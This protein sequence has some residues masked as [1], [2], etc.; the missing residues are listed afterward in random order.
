MIQHSQPISFQDTGCCSQE[1]YINGYHNQVI[2]ITKRLQQTIDQILSRSAIPPIIIVQGDHGPG[3]YYDGISMDELKT[4]DRMSILNAYYFPKPT[5]LLYP[6]ITPV[7]SFR[8]LFASQFNMDFPLLAD[9]SYFSPGNRPYEFS[10]IPL[11][12]LK[13]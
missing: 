8:V 7:N 12:W 3:A 4:Y 10:E 1:E 11:E 5:N 6:S 2:Y 9:M 13:K